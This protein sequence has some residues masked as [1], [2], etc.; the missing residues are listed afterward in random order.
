MN[1]IRKFA[2][3][4]PSVFVTYTPFTNPTSEGPSGVSNSGGST[5]NSESKLSDKDLM[6]MIKDID[7]LPSDMQVVFNQISMLTSA[8]GLPG[9]IGNLQNTYLKALQLVKT[10]SWNK[11][12]YDKAKKLVEE[13]GGLSEIAITPD[14]QVIVQNKEGQISQMGVKQFLEERASGNVQALTNSNLLYLRAHDNSLANKNDLFQVVQ[15][16]IGYEAINKMIND[17]ISSLGTIETERD[18]YQSIQ[19]KKGIRLLQE[20]VNKGIDVTDLQSVAGLYKSKVISKDQA[21]Q[22][23]LAINYVWTN[24]PTNAKTL[25]AL[26]S[27]NTQNPEQGALDQITMLISS[28]GSSTFKFE[29][30]LQADLDENGNKKDKTSSEKDSL[31]ENI[32]SQ[33]LY[34]RGAE[35]NLV[36]NPGGTLA[37]NIT[38]TKL[39]I[40]LG[41][42]SLSKI[43]SDSEFKGM[44][45]T[46]FATIDGVKINDAGWQH[47]INK[48][49][50]IYSVD[51]PIDIREKNATGI[52]KPDFQALQRMKQAD[53][54]IK[55]NN[56]VNP[57]EANKIYAKHQLPFKYD[58]RG[59]LI[60]SNY[61]RFGAMH[62]YADNKAF[63]GD[64]T[65]SNLRE[66]TD[67]NELET[68][69]SLMKQSNGWTDKEYRFDE[70]N[71]Y[72]WNGHDSM[73]SG[74]L[75][76][77]L[78]ENVFNALAGS[79]TSMTGTQSSN[80]Q[81]LQAQTDLMKR[82]QNPGSLQR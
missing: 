2:N 42:A 67:D 9:N 31:K 81:D 53:E 36:I 33:F 38:A 58:S 10:A 50:Q 74:I 80:L 69:I 18:G 56:I 47:I 32:A 11:T 41:Q 17:T 4:G 73:Y 24:L 21:N 39:P 13:K 44:L 43:M 72:D 52:I 5:T 61:A 62:V 30:D 23:Q 26:K 60:T 45:D 51:L 82:Y 76:V 3:G 29:T 66:V 6:T 57:D 70:D 20:L 27:G 48:D 22:I 40:G 12:E 25:L 65:F 77:P 14:G 35:E 75:Y 28:R 79:N 71:W 63:N 1:N 59:Q 15:N 78:I 49:G 37:L 55:A 7:G 64:V 34:G 19:T 54:E 68:S 46:R 16:G 8:A